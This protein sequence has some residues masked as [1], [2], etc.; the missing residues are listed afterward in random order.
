MTK[1][2]VGDDPCDGYRVVRGRRVSRGDKEIDLGTALVDV[3]GGRLP[4]V[5]TTSPHVVAAQAAGWLLA[6]SSPV[7]V[8]DLPAAGREAERMLTRAVALGRRRVGFGRSGGRRPIRRGYAGV[9]GE[10]ARTGRTPRTWL[11]CNGNWDRT[12]AELG[13]RRTS[14]WHRTGVVARELDIDLADVQRRMELWF[15]LR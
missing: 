2:V 4:A 9:L 8:A 5:V 6:V 1:M 13:V 7:G 10:P 15:A 12:A 3:E 14:V 11:A